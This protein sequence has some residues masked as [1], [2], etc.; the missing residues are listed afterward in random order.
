MAQ[1]PALVIALCW[2]A[3]LATAVVIAPS[4]PWLGA[5]ALALAIPCIGLAIAVRPAVLALALMAALL[6][7]SRAELPASDPNT[8]AN[9]VS[10]AGQT[11]TITGKVV[12]DTRPASGGSEALV[13]PDLVIIAG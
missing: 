7:V 1:A 13:S 12:D 11:A 5:T 2:S 9:A 4:Q 3:A 6:G 10:V 8:A